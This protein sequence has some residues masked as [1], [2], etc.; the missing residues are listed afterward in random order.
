MTSSARLITRTITAAGCL[1]LLLAGASACGTEDGT[2]AAAARPHT[3]TSIELAAGARASMNTYLQQL[4]AQAEIARQL[5]AQKADAARWLRGYPHQGKAPSYGD[6]RRQPV[7]QAD[8]D[9]APTAHHSPGYDK[10]LPGR[11]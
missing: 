1:A 4:H 6:D 5:R 10:A 3:A 7:G 2:Q 8:R 11:W 9:Q